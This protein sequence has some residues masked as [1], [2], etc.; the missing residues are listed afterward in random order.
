LFGAGVKRVQHLVAIFGN[1]VRAAVEPGVLVA[2][3]V[4]VAAVAGTGASLEQLGQSR[5]MVGAG[6]RNPDRLGLFRH[7]RIERR[8]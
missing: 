3:E 5:G 6:R 2:F 8:L 7:A 4:P 1:A